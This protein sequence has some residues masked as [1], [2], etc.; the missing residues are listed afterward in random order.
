MNVLKKLWKWMLPIVL[1]IV[2]GITVIKGR[3]ALKKK[4]R[5]DRRV[6]KAAS[7]SSEKR[8]KTINE[9]LAKSQAAEAK[10][11]KAKDD[12]SKVLD[13]LANDNPDTDELL[14]AW[15]SGRLSDTEDAA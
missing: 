12:A 1:G 2:F 13:K 7:E 14:D 6:N 11:K 10:A 5:A 9:H 15:N 3:S 4:G 8:W